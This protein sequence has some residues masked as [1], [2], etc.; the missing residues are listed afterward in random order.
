ML[1]DYREIKKTLDRFNK[2][3]NEFPK[4][5]SYTRQQL[6]N[7]S[8][9]LK[10]ELIPENKV[11][12]YYM[13]EFTEAVKLNEEMKSAITSITHSLNEYNKLKPGVE[14]FIRKM[15]ESEKE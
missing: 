2:L 6:S 10:N 15:N 3:K 12:E 8:K 14:E 7:L 13:I 5:V 1:S 4:E 9:D 11:K